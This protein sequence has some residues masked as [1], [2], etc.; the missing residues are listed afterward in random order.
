MKGREAKGRKKGK[1]RDREER[2]K[3]QIA[4][5]RK[6]GRNGK[7]RGGIRKRR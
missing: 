5:G 7:G 4:K 1:G 6:E 2:V 3:G